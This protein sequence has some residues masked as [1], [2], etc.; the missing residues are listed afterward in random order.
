MSRKLKAVYPKDW[1]ELPVEEQLEK[2]KRGCLLKEDKLQKVRKAL[3]SCKLK[4]EEFENIRSLWK[5]RRKAAMRYSLGAI[6][7]IA[8]YVLSFVLT[9]TSLGAYADS[10]NFSIS[11]HYNQSAATKLAGWAEKNK[12]D[13]Q[14]FWFGRTYDWP[15][16][17]H[18]TVSFGNGSGGTS[19]S[20][21]GRYMS[22]TIN[23]TGDGRTVHE[24]TLAHEGNHAV[25]FFEFHGKLPKWI[26]EGAS[27]YMESCDSHKKRRQQLRTLIIE[28]RFVPFSTIIENPYYGGK[29]TGSIYYPE[30]FTICEFLINQKGS[31]EFG[32]FMHTASVNGSLSAIKAHY[33]YDSYRDLEGHW[34]AWFQDWNTSTTSQAF[35]F[36]EY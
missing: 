24:N 23:A 7:L 5:S 36:P 27:S 20:Y 10:R 29:H 19:Y 12:N 33:G 35:Q 34:N 25:F 11:T 2:W 4:L 22:C 31:L 6:A 13:H 17:V 26:H 32:K 18:T 21:D 16:Q 1:D 3:A 30:A 8:I 9:H 15:V 28:R 14:M